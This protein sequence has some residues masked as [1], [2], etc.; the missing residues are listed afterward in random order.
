MKKQTVEYAKIMEDLRLIGDIFNNC[1][2]FR[3]SV[4]GSYWNRQSKTL[5]LELNILKATDS[6][7][8][9]LM[10]FKQLVKCINGRSFPFLV[11]FW[12]SFP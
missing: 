9:L 8:Q 12:S 10:Q 5:V 4:I 2:S 7:Q 3:V 6:K 11:P 1:V